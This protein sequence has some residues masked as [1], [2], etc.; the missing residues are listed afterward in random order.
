MKAPLKEYTLWKGMN[1]EQLYYLNMKFKSLINIDFKYVIRI[2]FKINNCF[3]YCYHWHTRRRTNLQ[4][5]FWKNSLIFQLVSDTFILG[6][7]FF[8]VLPFFSSPSQ[9]TYL[10]GRHS[11]VSYHTYHSHFHCHLK[12]Y[13]DLHLSHSIRHHQHL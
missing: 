8:S 3:T 2:L 12:S 7:A 13:F 10:Y 9:R 5:S 4:C 6:I 1:Y 11:E